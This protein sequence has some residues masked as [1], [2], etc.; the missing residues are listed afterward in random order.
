MAKSFYVGSRKGLFRV[1]RSGKGPSGWSIEQ[2]AFL[3]DPVS[4]VT[5]NPLTGMVHAALDLG[6]FGVKM[7][8]S[9]DRGATWTEVGCPA[10]PPKPEEDDDKVEIQGTPI[11]WKLIRVWAI[12]PGGPDQECFLWCGTIPGGLFRSEDN[13][14]SW[15]LIRSLWDHPGRR[16]WFGG[17]AEFPGIHSVC[18]DPRDSN[19]VAIGVSCG[20]VWMTEDG[21]GTWNCRAQGMRAEYM[22]PDQQFNPNIQDPHLIV[23]CP[24][25]P[26][27]LWAQHHNGIFLT[28]D[29]CQS[30]SEIAGGQPS[31]FGFAVAVHPTQP[32]TAWFVPAQ[33]DEKRIP[34]D[35]KVVVSRTRDGG[36][37][38]EVLSNGLP[39]D[40]AYD[41]TFRHCLAIDETGDVLAFGTTTGS[42]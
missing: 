16:E 26:N 4:I 23:R 33:K 42:L 38:F 18:V 25:E 11:P 22:P 10:Y 6:H 12:E 7:H 30:W 37:S 14:D 27:T 21:G 20:G 35:G 32:E 13:G 40:H 24:G 2:T 34:V 17:G 1:D 29:D 41:I 28:R 5:Q 8:R 3:A 31:G 39:Q 36:K 15:S 9:E 19:R